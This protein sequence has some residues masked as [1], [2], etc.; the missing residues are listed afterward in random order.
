[1]PPDAIALVDVS[2]EPVTLEVN[3]QTYAVSPLG[4]GDYV[5][6]EARLRD[7]RFKTFMRLTMNTPMTDEARGVA[8]ARVI[9]DPV[10]LN[11]LLLSYDS[12]LFMLWMSLRKRTPNVTLDQVQALTGV[13]VSILTQLMDLI[14]GPHK[15]EEEA[16]DNVPFQASEGAVEATT[17]PSDT[18][19]GPTN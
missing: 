17:L 15:G 19:T 3:G 4:P 13:T 11:D 14:T 12:R 2:S 9:G 7:Q 18:T 10:L 1:M 5:K 6:A 8:M 16:P